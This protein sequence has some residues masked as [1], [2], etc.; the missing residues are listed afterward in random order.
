MYL[1]ITTN[2]AGASPKGVQVKASSTSLLGF[3]T[4]EH[5][6]TGGTAGTV[7]GTDG[8]F[9]I[10]NGWAPYGIPGEVP[11]GKFKVS[12]DEGA[13][14]VFEFRGYPGAYQAPNNMTA[15]SGPGSIPAGYIT[16]RVDNDPARDQTVNFTAAEVANFDGGFSTYIL[17]G[18]KF[19]DVY[20]I[21]G[22]DFSF[23]TIS[24][25]KMG[26]DSNIEIIAGTAGLLTAMGWAIGF[27]PNLLDLGLGMGGPG[28][29][30]IKKD[31][32]SPV[33]VTINDL[34][35]AGATQLAAALTTVGITGATIVAEGVDE[36]AHDRTLTIENVLP[37]EAVGRFDVLSFDV[38]DSADPVE[39]IEIRIQLSGEVGTEIVHDG[40]GFV[41]YYAM[42]RCAR[43]SISGGFHYA[44]ERA[45]G[46]TSAPVV[47]AAPVS[48]LPVGV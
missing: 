26:S 18:Q 24:S 45:G 25:R 9:D 16:L 39:R 14:Q 37:A 6:G 47:T 32:G 40:N 22:D 36:G 48:G 42:P 43:T 38:L 31:A 19:R 44:I 41:G 29:V 33:S 4:T 30:T 11:G 17:M 10:A 34:A 27:G 3:G 15:Y 1:R 46:W 35:H 5:N 12:I 21:G 28:T 8:P 7:A 13:D 23:L 20:F 2:T